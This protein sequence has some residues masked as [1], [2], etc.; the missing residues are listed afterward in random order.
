MIAVD[1]N[2]NVNPE[3]NN[4]YNME[5]SYVHEKVN[6]DD[7]T[8]RFAFNKTK[9][10]SKQATHNSF[11]DTS[12]GFQYAIGDHAVNKINE[13]LTNEEIISSQA[14]QAVKQLNSTYLNFSV[15]L[16]FDTK[17]NTANYTII[18]EPISVTP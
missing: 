1:Q 10:I 12:E 7:P 16:S 2:G 9:A 11:F 6:E 15:T 18:M 5:N 3:A 13:A 4:I 14:Q 8:S 17:A